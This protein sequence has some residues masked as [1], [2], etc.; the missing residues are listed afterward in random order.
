LSASDTPEI[1]VI[2]QSDRI[3]SSVAS[4]TMGALDEKD[5]KYVIGKERH[6]A[7]PTK[8][9]RVSNGSN[10]AS[11]EHVEV[12]ES[13]KPKFTQRAILHYRRWWCLYVVGV[14]VFLAI[15]LPVL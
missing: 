11:A 1:G 2:K 7:D 8:G 10:G 14:I 15:F 13:P 9:K 6:F 4:F 3:F 12:V 5:S